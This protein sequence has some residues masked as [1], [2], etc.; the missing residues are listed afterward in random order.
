M[1]AGAFASVDQSA[2][3]NSLATTSG[4][5]FHVD[6]APAAPSKLT[7]TSC[8]LANYGVR[9]PPLTQALQPYT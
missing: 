4:A 8:A 9:S 1:S 2:F 3:N 6:S 5:S 7:L